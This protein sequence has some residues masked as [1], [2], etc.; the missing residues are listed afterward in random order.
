MNESMQNCDSFQTT[1][2]PIEG[3]NEAN[4]AF[5]VSAPLP[6]FP[7]I[8]FNYSTLLQ[9]IKVEKKYSNENVKI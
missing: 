7:A 4:E 2:G 5:E 3:L 6:N 1:C 9:R 8:I